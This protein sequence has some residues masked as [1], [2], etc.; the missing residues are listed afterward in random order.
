MGRYANLW[1]EDNSTLSN[2]VKYLVKL[3]AAI[4]NTKYHKVRHNV[5]DLNTL[6]NFVK[7]SAEIWNTKY[8]KVRHNVYDLNTLSN[9]VK[10]LVKLSAAIWNIKVHHKVSQYL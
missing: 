1:N 2:F 9:F 7:L 5:Y 6:S 8:H 10:Y 4:W 3:S